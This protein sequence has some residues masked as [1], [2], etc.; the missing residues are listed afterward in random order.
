MPYS[1]E[2]FPVLFARN[3]RHEERGHAFAN[4]ASGARE[5]F[6]RAGRLRCA[7]QV[8]LGN[9]VVLI[10]C[11]GLCPLVGEY[12][13]VAVAVAVEILDASPITRMVQVFGYVTSASALHVRFGPIAT[14]LM[15]R[16]E[17]TRRARTGLMHRSKQRCS[18][19]S[20]KRKP[21][22]LAGLIA[23]VRFA[24]TVL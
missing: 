6:R 23:P 21:R 7:L 2:K 14:E 1:H 16:N 3:V 13:D 15:R 18:I 17:L 10:P 22:S 4:S 11:A 19:T 24:E 20:P 12:R 9:G 5:C 8:G